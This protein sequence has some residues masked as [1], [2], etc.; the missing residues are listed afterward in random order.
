MELPESSEPADPPIIKI[1]LINKN[2]NGDSEEFEI[3]QPD[4]D[5]WIQ[6][7]PAV[8]IIQTLKIIR[9]W[10]ISNSTK[11]KTKNGIRKHITQWL[12][13]E[14]NRGGNKGKVGEDGLDKFLRRHQESI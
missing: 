1:P 3:Y 7:F 4:I 11:R 5:G 10:N 13:K 14:Q 9:E 8:D 2:R 12:S 6:S